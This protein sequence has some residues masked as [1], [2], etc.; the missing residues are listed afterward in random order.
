MGGCSSAPQI[1]GSLVPEVPTGDPTAAG[2]PGQVSVQRMA[3]IP[4]IPG[5]SQG[6]GQLLWAESPHKQDGPEPPFKGAVGDSSWDRAG[7]S[8][9]SILL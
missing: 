2:Q 7:I 6:L 5:I 8:S 4:G 9:T 1:W 3:I